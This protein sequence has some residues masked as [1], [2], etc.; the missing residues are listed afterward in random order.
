MSENSDDSSE[1]IVGIDLGTRFSCASVWRNKRFEIIP[2]N[3]GNRVIP[4][5]VSFYR[6]IKLVGSNAL[7]M[8]DVN[9]ANTIYDIKRI[10]GR[11]MDDEIINQIQKLVT[12][13]IVDDE[14]VHHNAVIELDKND[15]SLNQKLIYRPE[16]ICSYILSEIKKMSCNYLKQDNI[17]AVITVPAYFN[18]SQRQATLDSAK[19]AGIE[20][21]KI[22][23]EPTAASLCYG[24][25]GKK[26][27]SATGGNVIIY[28]L[29][30]GTLD[31]TLMNISNGVFRT[32]AVSGNGHLGGEDIDYI[33]MNHVMIDFKKKFKLKELEINKLSLVKLKNSVETAK[34]L[35]SS[36]EKAVICVD[37]FCMGHKLYYVLSRKNFEELCGKLFMLCMKPLDDVLA[38][39]KFT[40]DMIDDVILVGGSTRIPK[41]QNLILD[42]FRGTKIKKLNCTFN[43][44]EVVSAGA[45]IYGYIITHNNDPFTNNLMLLDIT[46][47]SLGVETL[48]K[49]MT[50]IIPRNTVIP[51]TETKIFSTDSDYQDSVSIK[52][53]EGERQLTKNNFHVGTFDLSGFE[54]GPRGYPTILITFH[55]DINN[56]L[57]VTAKEKKSNVQNSI[58]ITSTWGAKGRLS[59]Q[60]IDDI[61]AESEKNEEMD[62]LYAYK[63]ELVHIIT[64][65]C[66]SILLSIREK[67]YN[68]TKKEYSKIK[69]NI[70]SHLKWVNSKEIDQHDIDELEYRKKNISKIYSP[71]IILSNNKNIKFKENVITNNS[72]EIYGDDE[73]NESAGPSYVKIDT[74]NDLSDYSKQEI[75]ALKKTISDLCKNILS[76]V[77]NPISKF[78][79]EDIILITDYTF[80]VNIWLY[81]NTET[82]T[83]TYISKID[84]INKFT[85]D[86]MKKYD[87]E[88]F[89]KNDNFS[90]RD[91]LQLTCVT[92]HS[93]L[94]SNYFSLKPDEIDSLIKI[95]N[96][97]LYW[98]IE[99][100]NEDNIVYQEKINKINEI[101]NEIYHN[102]D[103]LKITDN[104]T[105]NIDY[106]SDDSESSDDFDD[107]QDN[108]E[109]L[110]QTKIRENI[111]Q[112]INSLP[113]IP[114]KIN[115]PYITDDNSNIISNQKKSQNENISNHHNSMSN[116]NKYHSSKNDQDHT[117][118]N[119]ND[120]TSKNDQNHTSKN[121]QDVLL[122]I[123]INK[124]MSGKIFKYK[125]IEYNGR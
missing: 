77:N 50:V 120:R 55:I 105:D 25:G 11:R 86:I 124:L 109:I 48:Q 81:T 31:V 28:D 79:D 116:N 106:E 35:L 38:S 34:K 21:L 107:L 58:E 87:E 1:C 108:S 32:L 119:N 8:K 83:L 40:R 20:V 42:Y 57:H 23:N 52:I 14:S 98:L 62:N 27:K 122:K 44:D 66:N 70:K 96:D 90:L 112:I 54:K 22:I 97:T 39:I 115:I 24:L 104:C 33:I 61:I 26:W 101:C 10:I 45:S 46:P 85:E 94:K 103:R 111:P 82:T 121:D 117:S 76:V 125:N 60:Q 88:I 56:I 123:D 92:L 12:Y 72:A 99:H 4:S 30:A 74:L 2:D 67:T 53:Y 37:D 47:L 41:I 68:L 114:K 6:S 93:S 15:Y 102:L 65:S 100:Q 17:R 91:E 59:K 36:V 71:Y 3:F 69:S 13:K 49:K 80:S 118:K 18:D 19:I 5:V 29:G 7:N 73:D 84:E 64:S 95:V 43:P 78:K 89:E 75:K 63:L 16:E 113:K 9:P 51:V 110:S